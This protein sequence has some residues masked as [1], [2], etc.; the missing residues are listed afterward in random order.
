MYLYVFHLCGVWYVHF[1]R[2]QVIG[3]PYIFFDYYSFFLY[4]Y[5]ENNVVGLIH[6]ILYISDTTY[7]GILDKYMVDTMVDNIQETMEL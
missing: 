7:D 4:D 2:R 5:D 3:F 6:T 1:Q